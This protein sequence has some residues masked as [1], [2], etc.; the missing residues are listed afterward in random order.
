MLDACKAARHDSS[1]DMPKQRG[2]L[3]VPET[4]NE[5]V[6]WYTTWVE[7]AP[8]VIC[9]IET[10]N[11]TITEVGFAVSD[12]R[13]I[14]I[15]FFARPNKNYWKTLEEEKQAWEIVRLICETKKLVGQNFAYDMKWLWQK[16]GIRCPGFVNDTMLLHHS[17]QPE[18]E[19]G[20]A[21]LASAYT[22]RP[23]WKFMRKESKSGKKGD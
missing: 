11:D 1:P 6:A 4:I 17:L 21:F 12:E 2:F 8:Y 7:P 13:A 15:P 23:A 19:K 10:E 5:L 18:M 14:C 20:L 9:D 16:M 22:D 3:C